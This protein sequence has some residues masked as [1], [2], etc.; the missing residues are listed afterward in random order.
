M[1]ARPQS[2][3]GY[4]NDRPSRARMFWRR[5]KRLLRPLL[6]LALLAGAAMGAAAMLHDSESEQHFAPLRARLIQMMPLKIVHIEITG[7]HLTTEASL[8]QALGTQPGAPMFGFSVEAAR[9]RIDALP[10]VDHATVERHLPDTVL[11]HL[12]ERSPVAV[13]QSHGTFQLINRAGERVPDQGMT[14]KDAEAFTKLPLV[15][16]DGANVAAAELIDAMDAQP[17][18]KSFVVAAVRVGDRRWNLTLRDGTTIL[19]PEGH[20]PAALARLARYEASD[21]L[22]ERPV[23]SIDMRLP[24]R[25]IIHQAPV[26]AAAPAPARPEGNP[27][28]SGGQSP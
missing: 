18:V 20:E 6:L 16:G 14:G 25:M 3:N 2:R 11:I 17:V 4:G 23:I 1:A 26:P 19:L 12:V 7:R 13:W 9:R 22:L 10:F 5:Q 27:Q 15:V 24:D 21:R 8:L 28:D